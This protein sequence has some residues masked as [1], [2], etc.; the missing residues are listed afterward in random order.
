MQLLR[1]HVIIRIVCNRFLAKD[2]KKLVRIQVFFF[3]PQATKKKTLE[4]NKEKKRGA[5]ST[6]RSQLASLPVPQRRSLG[7]P[8][9]FPAQ[10]LGHW[11]GHGERARAGGGGSLV[12]E[13]M[14]GRRAGRGRDRRGEEG[15]GGER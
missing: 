13:H 15:R 6:D 4:N 14:T 1:K 10:R 8:E 2:E 5:N 3:A 12:S 11:D 7:A 9:L